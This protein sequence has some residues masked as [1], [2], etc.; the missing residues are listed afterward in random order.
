MTHLPASSPGMSDRR[1]RTAGHQA[2]GA[3]AYGLQGL[4]AYW[5]LGSK[6]AGGGE[7]LRPRASKAYRLIGSEAKRLQGLRAYRPVGF[8]AAGGGVALGFMANWLKGLKAYRLEG[9]KAAGGGEVLGSKAY[10]LKGL[11]A[12]EP[13]ES[14]KRKDE[15]HQANSFNPTSNQ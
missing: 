13:P 11:K 1:L 9:S 10:G 14:E 5:P 4:K 6:A 8:K 3:K 12:L 2:L 15:C 7:F